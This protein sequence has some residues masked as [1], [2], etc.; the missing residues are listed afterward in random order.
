MIDGVL[1][2]EV[3]TPCDDVE[4][5][6]NK[7]NDTATRASLPWFSALNSNRCSLDEEDHREL[8]KSSEDVVEHLDSSEV[9]RFGVWRVFELGC[10]ATKE[11]WCCSD[12]PVSMVGA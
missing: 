4:N 11:K 1:E 10:A 5:K 12:C 8:E 6:D 2:R 7:A 3:R 9:L